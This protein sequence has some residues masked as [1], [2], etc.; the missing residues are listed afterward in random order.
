MRI[1]SSWLGAFDV[2]QEE[3]E[4]IRDLGERVYLVA[5]H[6]GAPLIG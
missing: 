1:I 6:R 4:E 3:I 2:W 5:A